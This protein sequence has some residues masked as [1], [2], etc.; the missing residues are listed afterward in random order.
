[1]ECDMD[2]G[3]W[4][5]T[6]S[7]P[8][9]STLT[10][11]VCAEQ[12]AGHVVSVEVTDPEGAI[13]VPRVEAD[14]CV[15]TSVGGKYSPVT[16]VA[17]ASTPLSASLDCYYCGIEDGVSQAL[18]GWTFEDVVDMLDNCEQQDTEGDCTAEGYC[19]WKEDMRA[20]TEDSGECTQ[21]PDYYATSCSGGE[22]AYVTW[23]AV[24]KTCFV[25]IGDACPANANCSLLL[26]DLN[27]P[28]SSSFGSEYEISACLPDVEVTLDLCGWDEEYVDGL[29]REHGACLTL[30]QDQC[31]DSDD[32]S[33]EWD[34]ESEACVLDLLGS[35]PDCENGQDA[36]QDLLTIF[37]ECFDVS[38]ETECDDMASCAYYVVTMTDTQPEDDGNDDGG[39]NAALIGGVVGGVAGTAAVAGLVFYVRK[40]RSS[41]VDPTHYMRTV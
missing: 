38:D 36:F 4:Q 21:D 18:C 40:R 20:W 27:D 35:E 10:L 29:L 3:T 28:M 5:F 8:P 24:H 30:D 32:V 22:D 2:E 19:A 23:L 41:A 11:T 14:G 17:T 7:G 25:L 26:L 39:S 1:M 15:S 37:S 6:M 33:C 16:V 34:E 12:G 31:A 13:L 9:E